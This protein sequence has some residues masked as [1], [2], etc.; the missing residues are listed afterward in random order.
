MTAA[1][2]SASRLE[3]LEVLI[4]VEHCPALPPSPSMSVYNH[5]YGS[6]PGASP[7][8]LQK[9]L[10]GSLGVSDSVPEDRTTSMTDPYVSPLRDVR[11]F[12]RRCAVIQELNWYGKNGRGQWI[13]SRP[14]GPTTPSKV[15]SNATVEYIPPSPT[16][17][18]GLTAAMWERV[19]QEEEAARV[20]WTPARVYRSGTEWIGINSEHYQAARAAEKEKEEQAVKEEKAARAAAKR[21]IIATLDV[22]TNVPKTPKI[23]REPSEASAGYRQ[24]PSSPVSPYQST[25][26]MPA[27]SSPKL[28]RRRVS[29]SAAVGTR[30]AIGEGQGRARAQSQGTAEALLCLPAK[31]DGIKAP[32][33]GNNGQGRGLRGASGGSKPNTS[34]PNS[35]NGRSPTHNAHKRSSTGGGSTPKN[36]N[37]GGNGNGSSGNRR[38]SAGAPNGPV[39]VAAGR[40]R[41]RKSAF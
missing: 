10:P 20:G 29:G 16:T 4:P 15:S 24:G 31:L 11:K 22:S 18:H 8:L 34:G 28:E 27:P 14:T 33:N 2:S 26:E 35:R 38:F 19:R 12:V 21:A 37:T 17:G 30:G 6:T 13:V 9:P 1:F 5:A 25:K 7:V 3:T 39:P 40:G 23:E 41:A 36:A 32:T